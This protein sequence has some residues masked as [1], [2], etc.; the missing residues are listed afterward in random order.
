MASISRGP[1]GRRVIQF[2]GV[3]GLRQTLR[4]GKV[5]QCAAESVKLRVEMILSAQLTGHA[6]D[7]ETA[8]WLA[9]LDREMNE[10]LAAVGLTERREHA[11]LKGFIDDYVGSIKERSVSRIREAGEKLI[12]CFGAQKR[13]R[14][15]APTDGSKFRQWLLSKGLAENTVRRNCGRAKQFF[16][17]A[18]R[19][20]LV[21][22]NPFGEVVSAVRANTARMRF[23]DRDMSAKVFEA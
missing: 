11:T 8:R 6:V 9:K 20:K 3:D 21:S 18:I 15:F 2:K 4:L 10:K 5:T 17:A 12:A 19:Q 1:N 14:D 22:E 13:L 16:W 23:I 7:D